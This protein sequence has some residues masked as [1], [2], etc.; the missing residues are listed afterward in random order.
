MMTLGPLTGALIRMRAMMVLAIT[1]VPNLQI[2]DHI[3]STNVT[4]FAQMEDE[5]VYLLSEVMHGRQG[6]FPVLPG[7]DQHR[8]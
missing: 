2:T 1:Y 4:W 8:S 6:G 3:I 7:D 5:L